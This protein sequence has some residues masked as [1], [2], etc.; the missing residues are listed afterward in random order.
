MTARTVSRRSFLGTSFLLSG[1]LSGSQF[2]GAP[3]AA[4][5]LRRSDADET[6]TADFEQ[7]VRANSSLRNIRKSTFAY[8]QLTQTGTTTTGSFASGVLLDNDGTLCLSAHGLNAKEIYLTFAPKPN[9]P[10]LMIADLSPAH[11]GIDIVFASMRDPSLI[12]KQGLEPI[13]LDP[14]MGSTQ[15]SGKKVV[16]VGWPGTTLVLNAAR[17]NAART[18]EVKFGCLHAIQGVTDRYL[19]QE[20]VSGIGTKSC[21]IVAHPHTFDSF[22]GGPVV[23][24]EGRYAG[25]LNAE[26]G[27]R[28]TLFTPAQTV[29]AAY[30][31]LFP[32]RAKKAGITMPITTQ[33]ERRERKSCQFN[34]TDFRPL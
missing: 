23:S 7:L 26:V 15:A 2:G 28:G 30:V 16:F 31:T 19:D 21:S 4:V 22:S 17:T 33:A 32:E 20:Y 12:K 3:E 14:T 1:L 18:P 25:L 8:A 34:K 11:R 9:T 27:D 13:K 5:Q 10:L 29:I 24:L 6:V